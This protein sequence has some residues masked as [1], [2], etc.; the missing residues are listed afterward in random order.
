MVQAKRERNRRVLLES[1]LLDTT[2]QLNAS[3][4]KTKSPEVLMPKQ[5]QQAVAVAVTVTVT[6][7]MRRKELQS[8]HQLQWQ[9]RPVQILTMVM[10]F[11]PKQ[12]QITVAVT[13]RNKELQSCPQLQGQGHAVQILTTAK[14]ALVVNS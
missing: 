10:V 4:G 12:H 14:V 5:H 1:G 2:K 13:L 9:G 7:T 8:G 11:M 6:V 3:V